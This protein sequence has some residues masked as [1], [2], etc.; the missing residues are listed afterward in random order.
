MTAL[1]REDGFTLT[2]L[3][4]ASALFALVIVVAGGIF[5]GQSQAQRQVSVVTSAATNAQAAG[6]SIDG[7][8]RNS[9]GFKLT[10][11]GG[12]QFL[13]ARVA[14]SA[15]TLQWECRAWYYSASAR[16]IRTTTVTP[17]TPMTAPT[18]TQLNNWVLL[19][20]GVSPRTG[21]TIFTASGATLS[22]AFNA[23]TGQGARP[24]AISLS[25]SPL[26]GVTENTTCY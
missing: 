15:A 20:S 23:V 4:V 19:V 14:G 12:D 13:V 10:A 5:I 21:T 25:T 7:G 1:R 18:S 26:A 8:I 3:L 17:G 11:V 16:T 2:E 24:V 22:V 6:N 9:S